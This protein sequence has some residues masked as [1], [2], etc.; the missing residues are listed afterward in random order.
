MKNNCMFSNTTNKEN[1]NM[2]KTNAIKKII[3]TSL[4]V[5]I[6]AIVAVSVSA[7]KTDSASFATKAEATRNAKTVECKINVKDGEVEVYDYNKTITVDGDNASVTEIEKILSDGFQLSESEKTSEITSVDK[8]SFCPLN[9]SFFQA[10]MTETKQGSNVVYSSSIDANTIKAFIGVSLDV[11]VKGEGLLSV[12]ADSE[13]ILE[14]TLSF[15]TS[16]D[17]DVIVSYVYAY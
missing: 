1:K 13:K 6:I 9:V 16:T 12:S 5:A 2:K 8:T 17:K 11:D 10:G 4:L 14:M 15:K 3:T 7:C